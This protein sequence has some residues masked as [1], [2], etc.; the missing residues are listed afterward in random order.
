[1]QY[2]FANLKIIALFHQNYVKIG[3]KLLKNLYYSKIRVKLDG[4]HDRTL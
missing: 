4:F 2:I 1:M 3:W